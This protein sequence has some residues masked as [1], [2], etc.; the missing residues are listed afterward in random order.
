MPLLTKPRKYQDEAV[1]IIEEKFD[2]RALLADDMGLGKSLTSMLWCWRNRDISTPI[3]VVCPASVKYNWEREA[4]IHFGLR[5]VVCEGQ[6]P[7]RIR[8]LIK[9]NLIIINYEIL[10]YWIDFLEALRPQTLIIDEA[11]YIKNP[12][13]MRTVSVLRL[14]QSCEFV[15]ALSGTPMTRKPSELWT[16]LNMLRPEKF[17]SEEKF[18]FRFC[19]PQLTMYGWEFNGASNRKQLNKVLRQT[20]M[21]RRTKSQVLKEL[22]P[23]TTSVVPF[24]LSKKEFAEYKKAET[25]FIKWVEE[26]YGTQKAQR[27]KR[28]QAYVKLGYL[29]R[30]AAE[31]K[32]K[33]TMQWID[34]MLEDSDEKI[35]VFGIHKNILK[36]LREKYLHC[37][38]LITGATPTKKR[39]YEVD[40]F[41]KD[42]KTRLFIANMV[43]GGVGIN[44]TA[45]TS[46]A[47]V[48]IGWT[49]AEHNQA[50]DRIHRLGQER[51]TNCYYLIANDTLESDL[52]R[53]LQTRS[54]M[55]DDIM[56]DGNGQNDVI[57]V[58]DLLISDVKQRKAKR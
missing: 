54:M 57:E 56:N 32:L 11:H 20:C 47:F 15:I 22:P 14:E 53:R 18:L 34:D 36:P 4:M 35:A 21:I 16:V 29:K 10:Q 55:F 48:E 37:S 1:R 41:Q 39:M 8:P 50:R 23:I 45:G 25:E 19:D 9:A 2:G 12:T 33:Q 17:R 46:A 52:C 42:P 26:N 13:T 51:P 40:K 28:A 24:K 30:L 44:L 5:A 38:S 3:I 58:Y 6:K 49:P 31:L 43:A 27:A 7:P